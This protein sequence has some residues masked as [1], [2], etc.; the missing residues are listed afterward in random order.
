MYPD[1]DLEFWSGLVSGYANIRWR[2]DYSFRA[3]SLCLSISDLNIPKSSPSLQQYYADFGVGYDVE[4]ENATF[5]D[6]TMARTPILYRSFAGDSAPPVITKCFDVMPIKETSTSS[7]PMAGEWQGEYT[8][9]TE[10]NLS[11]EK[12]VAR[13]IQRG[14]R[15]EGSMLSYEASGN[16]DQPKMKSKI[17]G[18]I[19]KNSITFIKTDDKALVGISYAAPFSAES[20]ELNGTWVVGLARG[21]WHMTR[22]GDLVG[23]VD[24][25]LGPELSNPPVSK[26]E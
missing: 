19:L 8:V 16:Q 22:T 26:S 18:W 15:F 17:E 6:G 20:T 21:E 7:F 23:S 3:N 4:L 24:E 12:L 11:H 14:N 1:V 13:L 2:G 9:G 25:F 10:D 5:G